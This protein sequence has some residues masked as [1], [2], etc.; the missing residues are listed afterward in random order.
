[1]SIKQEKKQIKTKQNILNAA[2]INIYWSRVE[3]ENAPS[4]I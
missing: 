4:Q 1:M 2:L 3:T